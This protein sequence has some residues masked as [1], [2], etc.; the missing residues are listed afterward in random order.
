MTA[1]T[2]AFAILKDYDSSVFELF[3]PSAHNWETQ[4]YPEW[5]RE[6]GVRQQNPYTGD[7]L[8]RLVDKGRM[9][10]AQRIADR[11]TDEWLQTDERFNE[12]F[13]EPDE[14]TGEPMWESP[15]D[16]TEWMRRNYYDAAFYDLSGWAW[17]G[18]GGHESENMQEVMGGGPSAFRLRTPQGNIPFHDR[19]ELAG[20]K[21]R[22]GI[23]PQIPLTH[24]Q[25]F[26]SRCRGL[27]NARAG[28]YGMKGQ[29]IQGHY[30]FPIDHYGYEEKDHWERGKHLPKI[31]GQFPFGLPAIHHGLEAHPDMQGP[32]TNR[33]GEDISHQVTV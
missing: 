19:D 20:Q 26:C 21:V 23:E 31:R 10:E 22:M 27:R 30:P 5:K 15:E 3:P 14:E 29:M 1:F 16:M 24:R 17:H 4:S 7:M 6:R 8:R 25:T 13:Y 18:V 2:R 33:A 11:K 28:P 32:K 12:A 9:A